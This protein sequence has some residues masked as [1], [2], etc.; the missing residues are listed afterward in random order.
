MAGG[1]EEK[2]Q[3]GWTWG[4]ARTHEEAEQ[5]DIAFWQAASPSDRLS[6][7]L[8]VSSDT[9]SLQYGHDASP[10][11]KDLLTAFARRRRALPRG[12]ASTG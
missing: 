1:P 8:A 7:I 6:A 5:A 10:D 11:F 2:S 3:D 12:W 9:W 4:V